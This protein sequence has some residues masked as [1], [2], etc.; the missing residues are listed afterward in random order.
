M[1]IDMK[2]DA[3]G[4]GHFSPTAMVRSLIAVTRR[5]D[6]SWAGKRLAF[7][8][9]GFAV[10]LLGGKPVDIESMGARMRLSPYNNVCEKRILFTP[11]LVA[12]DRGILSTIHAEL[13]PGRTLAEARA[14]LAATYADAPFVRLL[15]A[16]RWPSIA[17]VER[18]NCCDIALGADESGTHLVIASAI[19]NLVKGAAGQ[20]VQA[21]NVR[22]GFDE[23]TALGLARRIGT[24]VMS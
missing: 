14:C 19:D 12:L 5:C 3:R 16:G 1:Q 4:Y 24:E 2:M 23:T 22:F 11:H 17:A 7:L 10:R 8:L 13:A 15:P 20:A 9:R 21:F 18:T 6:A